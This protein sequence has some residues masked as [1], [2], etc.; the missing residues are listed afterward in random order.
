[1]YRFARSLAYKTMEEKIYQARPGRLR[2]AVEAFATRHISMVTSPASS[3][4][5][6]SRIDAQEA[7]TS[8]GQRRTR[9]TPTVPSDRRR[10]QRDSLDSHDVEPERFCIVEQLMGCEQKPFGTKTRAEPMQSAH[11][12]TRPG[13]ELVRDSTNSRYS[14]PSNSHG[15]GDDDNPTATPLDSSVPFLVT[16]PLLGSKMERKLPGM[17]LE[18]KADQISGECPTDLPTVLKNGCMKCE[19][20]AASK[21]SVHQLISSTGPGK[22][23]FLQLPN[24]LPLLSRGESQILENPLCDKRETY[25]HEA[26]KYSEKNE[27][28]LGELVIYDDGAAQLNIGQGRFDVVHGTVFFNSEILACIDQEKAKCAFLGEMCGRIVCIPDRSTLLA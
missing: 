19:D 23:L 9:F 13:P 2:G 14:Y 4:N 24:Y 3:K 25:A 6:D 12:A 28:E 22:F 5:P 1:M 7:S 18:Q 20:V 15:G 8:S 26:G 10:K 27:G 21:E 17:E 11:E 16:E